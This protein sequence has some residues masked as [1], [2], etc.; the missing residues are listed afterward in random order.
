M[1][2]GSSWCCVTETSVVLLGAGSQSSP[3]PPT[4][5]LQHR[6]DPH[7][8]HP[9]SRHTPRPHFTPCTGGLKHLLPS[10]FSP[11]SP[12]PPRPRCCPGRGRGPQ[13]CRR[14]RCLLFLSSTTRSTRRC[15]RDWGR[16]GAG[17]SRESRT[18]CTSA[19]SSGAA[20]ANAGDTIAAET[21]PAT[22]RRRVRLDQN[23]CRVK[24]QWQPHRAPRVPVPTHQP[25]RLPCLPGYAPA[26]Q[27][28]E[29]LPLP[30]Q[31]V[32]QEQHSSLLPLC[33][34]RT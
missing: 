26:L 34:Q 23:G 18:R 8:Q 19:A 31:F 21:S 17:V 15:S 14:G 9:P 16:A 4:S 6:G 30:Q 32:V 12:A 3:S 20:R 13:G 2:A 11:H 28:Q 5:I 1:C 33:R 25:G 7:P 24:G 27:V 22:R 29:I 10:T